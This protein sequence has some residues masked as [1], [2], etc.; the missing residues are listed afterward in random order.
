MSD[1]Q[2]R[3]WQMMRELDFCMLVTKPT[4]GLRGRPMSSIVKEDEGKIYF[5]S[6]VHGAKDEEIAKDPHILLCYG[7]GKG[8][9]VSTAATAL[10]KADRALVERLWNP[11]AQAFWPKG[12]SDPTVVVIEVTP[13]RAEYWDGSG[14]FVSSV[15]F[16]FALLT[17]TTPTMGDNAKVTL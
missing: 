8:K 3:A 4:H 10:I 17:S 9:F 11:G 1:D 16:A 12:A 2:A 14:G 6:D 15:K 13:I 7:D 5:L